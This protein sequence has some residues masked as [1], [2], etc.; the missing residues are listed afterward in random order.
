M[1]IDLG[2]VLAI[3]LEYIIFI[4]Y[5]DTLFYRK[6]SKY[7]CY[8]IVGSGYILN[9]VLC[10]FGNVIVNIITV[11]VIH[12]V[13]FKLCYYIS[14]KSAA[15]QSVLIDG[16]VTASEYIIVFIP[17]FGV[18]PVESLLL[19]P[20]QSFILTLTSRTLYLV[21]IMLISKLFKKKQKNVQN[22]SNGL[23]AIP[24]LTVTVI[25]LMIKVNINSNLLSLICLMLMVMNIIAFAINQKLMIME[26]EKADLEA[27][28][29]K[30]KFDYDEYIML[31]EAQRQT[32][33][34]NHDFK[35]HIDVLS[36]LVEADNEAAQQ[37]IRSM[38]DGITKSQ[39]IEYSDNKILNVLLSKKKEECESKGIQFFIDPIQ[40]S[41]KFLSDMDTVTVFSN[42]I[43]N[44]IE[45]CIKSSEKKIYLNIHTANETFV[46]IKVENTSDK[47]PI[48]INGRLKT[49]KD[50]SE[51][52]GI[53][54]NSIACA[55]K[56]YNGSLTWEY[57][58]TEKIFSTKIV[59]KHLTV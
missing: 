58:E 53:G 5:A 12:F 15:F 1:R 29:Q 49:H 13:C 8:A 26:T 10:M 11:F 19:T 23:L 57:N 34:L 35:A 31:K 22:V 32:A 30:E 41:L 54:M 16:M 59:V 25:A 43:N 4:Y 20:Q 24:I 14:N 40:V 37:Y 18:K 17:F 27:R 21:G 6:R 33:I 42:L 56:A 55:L 46:I 3:I 7:F 28:Q 51:L 9:F 36:S 39:F 44:A 48:V 2:L 38:T 47:K 45:S 52:H 50:N